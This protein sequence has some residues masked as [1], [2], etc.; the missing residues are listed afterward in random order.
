MYYPTKAFKS[1][2]HLGNTVNLNPKRERT[3]P[4]LIYSHE[5]YIK[6]GKVLAHLGF[7]FTVLH[8][9]LTDLSA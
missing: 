5:K 6:N 1:V 3:L 8:G 4:F 9:S 7:K 2:K